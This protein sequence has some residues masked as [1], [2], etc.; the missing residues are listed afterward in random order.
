MADDQTAGFDHGRVHHQPVLPAIVQGSVIGH[1]N[2]EPYPHLSDGPERSDRRC[3]RIEF[4]DA[5]SR[6]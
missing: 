2:A 4:G 6:S 1:S 5:M 3:C